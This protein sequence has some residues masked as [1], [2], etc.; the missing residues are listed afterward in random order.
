MG[1]AR[2]AAKINDYK[3]TFI[4]YLLVFSV[5]III[6]STFFF[7]NQY[8]TQLENTVSLNLSRFNQFT[9]EVDLFYSSLQDIAI[10]MS[11]DDI[12]PDEENNDQFAQML[13]RYSEELGDDVLILYYL[14]GKNS[15]YVRDQEMTY[16]EFEN[17]EYYDVSLSVSGLYSRLNNVLSTYYLPIRSVNGNE[18]YSTAVLL[19][20]PLSGGEVKGSLCFLI[21]SDYFDNLYAEYFPG[22][23]S[24]MYIMN[25]YFDPIYTKESGNDSNL[26]DT[27]QQLA[28]LPVGYSEISTADSRLSVMKNRNIRTGFS[29]LIIS[30]SEEFF[31]ESRTS[32]GILTF[33]SVA[34]L[35][36]SALMSLIIAKRYYLTLFREK[37]KNEN[38]SNELE[39]KNLLIMEIVLHK[40]VDGSI[41]DNDKSSLDYNLKCANLYFYYPL[42][43]VFTLLL[44]Y[45]MTE[46]EVSRIQSEI[47]KGAEGIDAYTC[48]RGRH[49]TLVIILNH[50][51]SKDRDSLSHYLMRQLENEMKDIFIYG[52]STYDSPFKIDDSYIESVYMQEHSHLDKSGIELFVKDVSDKSGFRYPEQEESIITQAVMNTSTDA[53][54]SA[55]S[56]IF[57]LIN[58]CKSPVIQKGIC[59]DLVNHIVRLSMEIEGTWGGDL[60]TK[61]L[62]YPDTV[63][64]EQELINL[65][66]RLSQVQS[67]KM[68]EEIIKNRH[69]IISYVQEHYRDK[70][71]SLDLL[72]SLFSLS[73]SYIGR[74]FKDETNTTFKNYVTE[75][76]YAYVKEQLRNT[77]DAINDIIH[78]AGYSD[79]ANYMRKF[80][81]HEG[82][83]MG[84][85]RSQL[86]KE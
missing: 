27:I 50:D 21:K 66:I 45:S 85:Y 15:I 9:Q 16:T 44:E 48:Q 84:Q 60:M 28:F 83:T 57:S 73:F 17:S 34:L 43:T 65:I 36:F 76:R 47:E 32:L 53:A 54:L 67:R 14:R 12:L 77:D 51:K 55:L 2:M 62:S 52:G 35:L 42:F 72:S 75:L 64:L 30:E 3:G 5:P 58:D 74:I 40:L 82:I 6:F 1:E 19:P 46:E 69:D 86:R 8:S 79:A 31:S 49:N 11:R 33:L 61:L 23:N 29:Y 20:L 13:W 26:E 10:S 41:R 7:Y 4:K 68:E 39:H 18:I 80:K 59:Y 81:L 70:E 63:W 24:Q 22:K 38:I 71:L 56:N 25:T 78:N 37:Q